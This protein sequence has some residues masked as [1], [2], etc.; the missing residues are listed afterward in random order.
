MTEKEARLILDVR[1]SRFDHAQDVNEA[2][3][4]AKQALEEI[5]QYRAIGT[6]DEC[7][8]A[9]EKQKPKKPEYYGDLEDGKILCP[10]CQEDLFDLKECGF[11]TCPYCGQAIDW[12]VEEPDTHIRTCE[13]C[14][15]AAGNDCK[16]CKEG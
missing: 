7:R 11:N 16:R 12:S 4:I 13:G 1:I 9:R 8:E 14:F 2:L 5:R 15:G 3:E 6:V 10:D